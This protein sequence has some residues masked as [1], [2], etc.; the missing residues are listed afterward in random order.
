VVRWRIRVATA[1]CADDECC[2]F[3]LV[4]LRT[5][6]IALNPFPCP[7]IFAAAFPNTGSL[8]LRHTPGIALCFD[9]GSETPFLSW[10]SLAH[11][12]ATSEEAR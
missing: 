3:S 4:A 7:A 1:C 9:K 11:S 10:Y 6:E 8:S 12:G 5:G 2:V